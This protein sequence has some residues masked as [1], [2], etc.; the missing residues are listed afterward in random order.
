MKF[1]SQIEKSAEIHWQQAGK[2]LPSFEDDGALL[3]LIEQSQAGCEVSMAGLV[4]IMHKSATNASA[5][6]AW[7][8]EHD[9]EGVH[10]QAAAMS[11]LWLAV[12]A[13][14]TNTHT[15]RVGRRLAADVRYMARKPIRYGEARHSNP[16]GLD[17][18]MSGQPALATTANSEAFKRVETKLFVQQT[19]ER[20][21]VNDVQRAFITEIVDNDLSKTEAATFLDIPIGSISRHQRALSKAFTDDYAA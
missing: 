10:G 6:Y 19:L 1:K 12:H 2:M 17:L 11:M 7:A 4:L 15:V 13:F 18:P 20:S 3:G 9:V 5:Q 14:D 8:L 16:T 21:D